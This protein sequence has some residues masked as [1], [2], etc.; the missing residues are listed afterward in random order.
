M[1]LLT[2]QKACNACQL[3]GRRARQRIFPRIT[4]NHDGQTL[5]MWWHWRWLFN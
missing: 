3:C 5:L 4:R 1:K 2:T